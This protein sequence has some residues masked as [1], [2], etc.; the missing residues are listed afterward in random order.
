M[1]RLRSRR[2]L[3]QCDEYS[4]FRIY[5]IHH[6]VAKLAAIVD[7]AFTRAEIS[8]VDLLIDKK[9]NRHRPIVDQCSKN[10]IIHFSFSS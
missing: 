9:R 8:A 1:S 4:K 5:N 7:D 6:V 3:Q 2:V 10:Y